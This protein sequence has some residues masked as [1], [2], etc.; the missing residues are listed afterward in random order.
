MSEHH[1]D[2][3]MIYHSRKPDQPWQQDQDGNQRAVRPRRRSRNRSLVIILIDVAVILLIYAVVS[4]F[5]S[6]DSWRGTIAGVEAELHLLSSDQNSVWEVRLTRRRGAEAEPRTQIVTVVF[7]DGE[8]FESEPIMDVVPQRS[9]ETR[10][11]DTVGP[12]DAAVVRAE[13]T[14]NSEVLLLERRPRDSR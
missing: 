8:S 4:T 2:G 5:I 11:L 7:S 12:Q 3:R 10:V 13:V 14:V 6:S 9:G 1:D